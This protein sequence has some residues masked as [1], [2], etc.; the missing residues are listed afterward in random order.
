MIWDMLKLYA[1]TLLWNI[2]LFD[3]FFFVVSQDTE[4]VMLG[5][6]ARF[7]CLMIYFNFA[8]FI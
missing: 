2:Y 6:N 3:H 1:S 8:L 7:V 4:I 5:Y